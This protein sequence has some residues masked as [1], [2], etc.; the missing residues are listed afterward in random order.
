MSPNDWQ[1]KLE[2]LNF[3]PSGAVR[4]RVWERITRRAA[5]PRKLVWAVCAAF[6]FAAGWMTLSHLPFSP[7]TAAAEALSEE[8]CAAL[9]SRYLLAKA[10]AEHE[11]G[12]PCEKGLN[13]YDRR[14][15]L[16]L[17]KELESVAYTVCSPKE[18]RRLKQCNLKYPSQIKE[19]KFCR[20][21]C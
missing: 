8:D 2:R 9:N 20:T 12:C 5:R 19:L 14:T 18:R 1:K 17:R 6:V 11:D 7:G 13:S 15:M 21:W 10:L 4:Q 3:D 16:H